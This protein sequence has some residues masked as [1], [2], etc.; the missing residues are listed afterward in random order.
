MIHDLS[1]FLPDLNWRDT[2]VKV[3]ALAIVGS[4]ALGIAGGVYYWY[5]HT[6]QERAQ[7]AFSESLDGWN[8]ALM[9]LMQG[10]V[11]PQEA[12]EQWQ[13]LE[14]SFAHAHERNRGSSLAPY[15]Q[16]FQ[17]QMM[18]L[19]GHLQE[20]YTL[21]KQVLPALRTS[22]YIGLYK[23]YAALLATELP[24]HV[25]EGAETLQTLANDAQNP[26]RALALVHW[27]QYKIATNEVPAALQ[28]W[29]T[30]VE[31]EKNTSPEQRVAPAAAMAQQLLVQY[32]S[33]ADQ[34]VV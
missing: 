6:S 2:R 15:M 31:I 5:Y 27:G 9:R 3:A 20:S 4:L 11:S 34:L 22:P 32:G 30:A 1:F 29:H 14:V 26:Y 10:K 23:M 17:A 8:V 12:Q 19:Q 21:Q 16:L 25:T 13:E 24:E 28:A 18:A 33:I 7:A